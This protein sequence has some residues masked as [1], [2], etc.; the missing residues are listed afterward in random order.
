M[1]THRFFVDPQAVSADE[2]LLTGEQA[3][4]IYRVLRLRPP[5]QIIVL[6]NRGWQ[7]HVTLA[8]V[9]NERV[10]G[11]VTARERAANEPQA[12]LTLYQSLLK[13]DNFEWILQKGTEL[14][15]A[16]FVPMVSQ[17]SVVRQ[18]AVKENKWARWQRIVAE[19]A[20]QSGRGHLPLL[21]Q[22]MA[23]DAA[24]A[25][26]QSNDLALIPWEEEQ[27]MAL[28][29]RVQQALT[30]RDNGVLQVALF[31]G[32][33]GGYAAEEIASAKANGVLPVTL[34]PRILRAETA[35][36][37]ATA[38]LMGALGDLQQVPLGAGGK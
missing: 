10:L 9:S 20:E 2:V 27:E 15:V 34:G 6:D 7:Y 25:D 16:V 11:Q 33:E 26:S 37:A 36:I 29:Q 18:L 19:A 13:K 3:R 8:S 38:L 32:P 17:R 24:V 1:T 5:E 21:R 4:Q 28:L 31:I 35:A 12:R 22:P 23:F 14:G 30:S